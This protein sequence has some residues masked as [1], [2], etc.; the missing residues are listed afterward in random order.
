MAPE[1]VVGRRQLLGSSVADRIGELV[2]NNVS[3]SGCDS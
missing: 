3:S 2:Q 1:S